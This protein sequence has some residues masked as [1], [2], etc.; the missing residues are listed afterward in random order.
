MG[1][2]RERRH[3]VGSIVRGIVLAALVVVVA[4]AV[5]ADGDVLA[6]PAVALVGLAAIAVAV[7]GLVYWQLTVGWSAG[8]L[9]RRAHLTPDRV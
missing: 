7:V 8:W 6:M 5:V 3:L 2:T 1:D 9:A 4:P